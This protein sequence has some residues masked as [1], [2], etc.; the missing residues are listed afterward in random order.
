MA[1]ELSKGNLAMEFRGEGKGVNFIIFVD[2]GILEVI[3]V[4]GH[5][6][7]DFNY[8]RVVEAAGYEIVKG[9]GEKY[10]GGGV[11]RPGGVG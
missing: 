10:V 2:A 8:E 4:L 11:A 3:Y 7:H 5:F 9:A 6:L 1:E